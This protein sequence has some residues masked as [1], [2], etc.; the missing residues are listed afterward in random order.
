MQLTLLG[1]D[2]EVLMSYDSKET[3]QIFH[4]SIDSIEI[5]FKDGTVFRST[6]A[7]EQKVKGMKLNGV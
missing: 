6:T 7:D 3:E 5:K 2:M 1:E 4:N